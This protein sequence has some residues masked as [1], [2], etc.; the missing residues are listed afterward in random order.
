LYGGLENEAVAS[1]SES[2]DNGDGDIS[3][4][5]YLGSDDLGDE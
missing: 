1:S 2:E 3:M 4:H 5:Q